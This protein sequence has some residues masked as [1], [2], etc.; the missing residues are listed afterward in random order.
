LINAVKRLIDMN[1]N[2]ILDVIG[3][4]ELAE[5]L[6]KQVNSLGLERQINLLGARS[7]EEVAE[8][9]Q[10][11]DLFVLPSFAESFGVV[12]IEAIACGKP[13]VSTYCGGPKDIITKEV[14]ILIKPGDEN[15]LVEAI[16]YV[17]DNPQKYDAKKIRAYAEHKFD[18]DLVTSKIMELYH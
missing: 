17:L 13:V 9:M 6:K 16:K 14:G 3:D 8:Y 12:V 11:C 2:I 10:N 4:G 1:Y 7:N 15:A 18:I 5:Q